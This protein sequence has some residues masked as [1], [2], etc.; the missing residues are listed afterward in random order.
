MRI[1][2]VLPDGDIQ[3]MAVEK[4]PYEWRVPVITFPKFT[5]E[6]SLPLPTEKIILKFDK[7]VSLSSGLPVY[8]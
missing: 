7:E 6:V 4:R 8:L 5:M 1:R 2:L 3:D